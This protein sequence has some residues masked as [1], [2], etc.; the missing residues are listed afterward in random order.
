LRRA[1]NIVG[2]ST[3]VDAPAWTV[4]LVCGASGVGKS[5]IAIALARRYGVP[6]AEVD[7]M[8][9]V[10]KA[11]TTPEQL[12][13]LH[14]W[15]TNVAARQ[16]TPTRIV[17]HT[18]AV[19]EVMQPGIEAVVTDHIESAAPVVMEGDYLLPDVGARFGD[20]VRTVVIS[21]SDEEQ[22]VANYLS[23]KRG[24]A[25]QRFRAIVSTA[26]DAALSVRA[27]RIGVPVVDARPWSDNVDRVDAALRC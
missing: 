9:T 13:T 12:P 1:A 16:W 23:R 5:H 22:I 8:V 2:M 11:L 7:D 3:A 24:A 10:V 18:I 17:E 6:L 4:T 14:L 19:A 27:A 25:E 26:F 20:H 21:E 15:D